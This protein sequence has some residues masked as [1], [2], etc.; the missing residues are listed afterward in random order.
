MQTEDNEGLIGP[1]GLLVRR[2]RRGVLET[3][4]TLTK[5]GDEATV[6]TIV[7]AI[8]Q[9]VQM[10]NFVTLA[11]S[12][13][14]TLSGLDRGGLASIGQTTGPLSN[15]FLM[16]GPVA[17]V[18][19]YWVSVTWVTLFLAL[20]GYSAFSFATERF[21]VLWPL[22]LLSA[23]A[24]YS[25]N[26]AFIPL[27]TSLMAG[28][29][30][31]LNTNLDFWRSAGFPCASP[32]FSAQIVLTAGLTLAFVALCF[33]FTLVFFDSDPCSNNISARAHGRV[34]AIFLALNILLV[35]TVNVYQSDSPIVYVFIFA[36]CGLVWLCAFV[37]FLPFYSAIMNR[38]GCSMSALF[39]W[40]VVCFSLQE[41]NVIPDLTY[42]FLAGS[43]LAFLSGLMLFSARAHCIM[44]TPPARLISPYDIE[45]KARIVVHDALYGHITDRIGLGV[46]MG[47]LRAPY[48]LIPPAAPEKSSHDSGRPP[49]SLLARKQ[50]VLRSQGSSLHSSPSSHHVSI[51]EGNRVK[52]ATTKGDKVSGA[53]SAPGG[54]TR[55]S[56]V[57]NNAPAASGFQALESDDDEAAA[58]KVDDMH[59]DSIE[60]A[61]AA[62]DIEVRRT[63]IRSLLSPALIN[64]LQQMYRAGVSRFRTSAILHVFFSRF[65]YNLQNNRHMQLTHLL[66]AERRSPP[67]D[68]AFLAFVGRRANESSQSNG[69][70]GAL[71]AVARVSL[72]KH[73]QDARYHVLRSALRAVSFFSEL[74]ETVPELSRLHTHS[75]EMMTSISAAELAFRELTALSPSSVVVMR[76]NSNFQSCV[77]RNA[78]RAAALLNEA[79]RIDQQ[80]S[81]ERSSEGS[82]SLVFMATSNL[83]V[84]SE[85]TALATLASSARSLGQIVSTNSVLLKVYGYRRLS[86]TR[87]PIWELM[88]S[89]MSSVL[90]RLVQRYMATGE[91]NISAARIVFG[92]HRAGYIFPIVISLRESSAEEGAHNLLFA[93]RPVET[94]DNYILLAYDFQLL[95]ASHETYVVLGLVLGAS[96]AD[97]SIYDWVLDWDDLVPALLRPHGTQLA[98]EPLV[99]DAAPDAVHVSNDNDSENDATSDSDSAAVQETNLLLSSTLPDNRPAA[100]CQA[101]APTIVK[102]HLQLVTAGGG[103]K[104]NFY[105]LSWRPVVPAQGPRS[106]LP[107]RSDLKP[108]ID[109]AED[110]SLA[111]S[112]LRPNV[113]QPSSISAVDEAYTLLGLS[114]AP[115]QSSALPAGPP[116]S[117]QSR[118][119]LGSA[120][121]SASSGQASGTGLGSTSSSSVPLSSSLQGVKKSSLRRSSLGSRSS[122]VDSLRLSSYDLQSASEDSNASSGTNQSSRAS[123]NS[124][125]V[126]RLRK[127]LDGP[128]LTLNGLR[129]LRIVGVFVVMV[130]IILAVGMVVLTDMQFSLFSKNLR[131]TT[132]CARRILVNFNIVMAVQVLVE[133]AR[134]YSPQSAETLAAASSHILNNVTIFASLHREAW[135][136]ISA[137]PYSSRYTQR[138]IPMIVYDT[139]DAGPDGA[140]RYVNLLETGLALASYA[141][142]AAVLS[143]SELANDENPIVKYILV[144]HIS[145][146]ASK[147]FMMDSLELG[148][149]IGKDT[150][151]SLTSSQTI[152]FVAMLSLLAA[153]GGLVIVPILM[154]I[155]NEK[156]TITVALVE[157]P[158]ILRHFL[159]VGAQRRLSDLRACF[160]EDNE[161]EEDDKYHE[162]DEFSKNGDAFAVPTGVAA[163]LAGEVRKFDIKEDGEPDWSAVLA[164]RDVRDKSS[165]GSARACVCLPSFCSFCTRGKHIEPSFRKSP[166]SIAALV[167]RFIGPLAAVLVFYSILFATSTDCLIKVL[168]IGAALVG[169]SNRMACSREVL[170]NVRRDIASYGDREFLRAR[171]AVVMDSATCVM[172]HEDLMLYG[173]FGKSRGLYSEALTASENGANPY[174]SAAENKLISNA[175]LHDLCLWSQSREMLS[176]DT[177]IV[178][179]RNCSDFDHGLNGGGIYVVSRFYVDQVTILEDRRLRARLLNADNCSVR[180]GRGIMLP[181]SSYN[182]SSDFDGRAATTTLKHSE[183]APSRDDQL[184]LLMPFPLSTFKGDGAS[185]DLALLKRGTLGAEEYSIG[186]ELSSAEMTK[187]LQIDALYLTPAFAHFT[188]FYS[189]TAQHTIEVN[190]SFLHI[191]LA[192]FLTVLITFMVLIF[193]PQISATNCEIVSKRGLLLC[194]PGEVINGHDRLK[195]LVDDIISADSGI[196]SD[197][198]ATILRSKKRGG[199]L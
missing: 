109:L 188:S 7:K 93:A 3:L 145:G 121:A 156:D 195:C 125:T 65:H 88:P 198:G 161:G 50:S 128:P 73:M 71:S 139:A 8:I 98:F 15:V 152:V 70:D 130:S 142:R 61:D 14:S 159:L 108:K 147:E 27:L 180:T 149:D 196:S 46:Y 187:L 18:Y 99:D 4:A 127:I 48:S 164:S 174:L 96:L 106:D 124:R 9:G 148:Y 132:V 80:L 163:S 102:A 45:I 131:Y 178:S 81:K 101:A 35:L 29:S 20:F 151:D 137:T 95:G 55:S 103:R 56:S 39:L 153:V 38:A 67:I 104:S 52:K 75:A 154:I 173:V 171:Y 86:L 110:S 126:S 24:S 51:S 82:T 40:C 89:V 68:V 189:R 181:A 62:D 160:A 112:L 32:S 74:S 63:V 197:G 158:L 79:T 166:W 13:L 42:C 143:K 2:V 162:D 107:G 133:D 185:E 37:F 41:F 120:V 118:R 64:D 94:P 140:L 135:S 182:Y 119:A 53:A 129:M 25:S 192:V 175:Q 5:R 176:E 183:S 170:M 117:E 44:R 111:S 85:A 60:D 136:I 33:A 169:A 31:G 54:I 43:P 28:F 186:A 16:L 78:E 168:S 193:L 115:G 84:M 21:S 1:F 146:G 138:F 77:T 12:T 90:E 59:V 199:G 66:Q 194:I 165:S 69:P 58:V 87:R 179:D 26:E 155:E 30:C 91:G 57:Y 34:D 19:F 191:S 47:G 105:I 123:N 49:G 36:F 114:S 172:F 184:H 76:L 157:L 122:K 167:G 23:V 22:R 141:S 97:F 100:G 72:E 10:I 6:R 92:L 144:N 190:S 83:T 177:S 150:G 134:G 116:S 113:S 17:S 11:S